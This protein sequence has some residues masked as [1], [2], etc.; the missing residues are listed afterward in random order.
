MNWWELI[1]RLFV[2][3]IF[4]TFSVKTFA[5][6]YVYEVTT[7]DRRF[8]TA[9]KLSPHTFLLSNGGKDLIKE[10]KIVKIYADNDFKRALKE[11]KLE[12][13]NANILLPKKVLDDR[14]FNPYI[15]WR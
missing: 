1:V 2:F 7:S 8:Q 6:T 3:L 15:W 13:E 10:L 11:F 14:S 5:Y 4:I 12:S 9:S